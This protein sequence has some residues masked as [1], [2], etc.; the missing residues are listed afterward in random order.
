MGEATITVVEV[1]E[2]T[3]HNSRLQLLPSS[4]RR[5]LR[6]GPKVL[7]PQQGQ[8]GRK[9]PRLMIRMTIFRS[10]PL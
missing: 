5:D 2:A 4:H 1:A 10:K 9:H 8:Q 3:V 7:R 6:A